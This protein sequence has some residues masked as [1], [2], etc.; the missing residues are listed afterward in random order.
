MVDYKNKEKRQRVTQEK[1]EQLGIT[2]EQPITWLKSMRDRAG[3]PPRSSLLA[4]E[5]SSSLTVTSGYAKISV[6][7][8]IT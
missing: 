8:R 6:T 5:H 7:S 4:L 1:A 2:A 3:K